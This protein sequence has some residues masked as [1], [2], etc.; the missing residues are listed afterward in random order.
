MNLSPLARTAAILAADAANYSRAMSIDEARALAALEASRAVIDA[1][2]TAKG[3][4]IFSTGGDS[5]LAEFPQ[6]E[7]AIA[8]AVEMQR[9]LAKT[10]ARG[11]ETLPYRIGVHV[12]RVY[13]SGPDLL[14]ETVNIAAR[15]E[16]IAYAG[17]ICLSERALAASAPPTDLQI[18]GM[19]A[20]TLKGIKEPIR[21]A[22][23]R[24]GEPDPDIESESGFSLAVLPFRASGDD[25]HWGE[26]LADDLIAALSRFNTLAVRSRASSFDFDPDKD[27]QHVAAA[28]GV[29]YVATGAVRRTASRLRLQ[30]SLIEGVSGR[31]LW[32]ER[33]D[34]AA[35]D[36]LDV[37]DEL[38]EQIVATLVGQ[39]HDAGAGVALRKRP[40]SLDA[41]DL[42]MRGLHYADRLDPAS[43]ES[44]IRCFE[45]SLALAPDYPA[46]TAMLAL[47]RLRDWALH[48]GERDIGPVAF[49]AERAL[50]L[51]PA[52]SF[53]HLV[54][55]QVDMYNKRLDAAE[56]HHKKA[57]ALNP[58]D[59][60]V[61][62]LWSPLA[63]YL[64]KPEEGRR[65]IERAMELNPRHPAWYVTNL[66]LARYCSRTY[67][68]GAAAYESV[69]SPQIGVLAGL[70]ACRAQ[71]GDIE[72]AGVAR[73][74]L[75]AMAPNFRA[76]F[77]ADSRPFKFAEDREHL[78][79]GLRKAGLPQ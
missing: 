2:V 9:S 28:L 54:A 41:F 38:I 75:I 34:R 19:G 6:A 20:Q 12:G 26:G 76:S 44:A 35:A 64:G 40:D 49:L 10:K 5:V 13:P 46:A 47:M 8:C 29:R 23:I 78:L 52:D 79:E 36:V 58:Y 77:F 21:A 57:H 39:L 70:A 59:A 45:Q 11:V 42:L 24:L 17:G 50:T 69:A 67:A 7:S 71:L 72:R 4:R 3:G 32:A 66:G 18:E 48:P 14:G 1:A 22:R 15:L 51:D 60:R 61:L 63:T 65:R 25:R 30:A 56:V 27:P 68:E 74:A 62:A 73:A 53:S 37:Q 31:V 16:G 33:Y 55:G 43:A